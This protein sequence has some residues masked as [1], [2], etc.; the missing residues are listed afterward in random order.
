MM[1]LGGYGLADGSIQKVGSEGDLTSSPPV[2]GAEAGVY[3]NRRVERR[4]RPAGLGTPFDPVAE[5][6]D[7]DGGLG[8]RLSGWCWKHRSRRRGKWL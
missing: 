5:A 6:V 1:G 4:P 8:R 7:T 3:A 2:N